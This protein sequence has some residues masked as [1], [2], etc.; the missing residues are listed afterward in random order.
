MERSEYRRLPHR[1]KDSCFACSPN[2]ASGLH[3]EFFTNGEKV[4]SWLR[5]PKHLSGWD[6]IVHGGVIATIL[7]EVMGWSA[8]RCAGPA[9]GPPS[10]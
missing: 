7:D 10:G 9:S 1:E 6:N 8:L 2:N 5:V 4:V 3:M